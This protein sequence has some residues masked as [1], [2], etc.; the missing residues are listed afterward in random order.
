MDR[1]TMWALNL[2][3][4]NLV[5]VLMEPFN[6]HQKN[7]LRKLILK[8]SELLPT[9]ALFKDKGFKYHGLRYTL[10]NEAYNL[11]LPTLSDSLV[12]E[13]LTW[14]ATEFE[15]EEII[16][17]VNQFIVVACI[18]APNLETFLSSLPPVFDAFINK[19]SV[20]RTWK[21]TQTIPLNA[22]AALL[23]KDVEPLIKQ[24]LGLSLL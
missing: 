23:W 15:G 21:R 13:F 18:N 19:C 14:K 22:N 20:T 10:D 11:D 8:N 16:K 7:N 12:P 3:H 1:N 24:Q 2:Y 9:E 5:E 17:K 4:E 6:Q